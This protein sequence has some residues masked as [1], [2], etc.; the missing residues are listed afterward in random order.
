MAT[1]GRFLWIFRGCE[2]VMTERDFT[3][4]AGFICLHIGAFRQHMVLA[5][6]A[7]GLLCE[8][9]AT[10][11]EERFE[12]FQEYLEEEHA[13]EGTEAELFIDQ[14]RKEDQCHS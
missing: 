1:T 2:M 11:L 7:T 4:V 3:I 14:L 8:L 6:T 13:I 5:S 12:Y 10:F 9:F